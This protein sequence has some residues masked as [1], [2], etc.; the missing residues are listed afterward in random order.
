[1]LL[2][3][4]QCTVQTPQQIIIQMSIVP[5]LDQLEQNPES[6]GHTVEKGRGIA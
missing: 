5:A 3:I 6:W 1:M 4:L 2:N